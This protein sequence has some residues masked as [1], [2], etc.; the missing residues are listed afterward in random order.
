VA[1]ALLLALLPT[2]LP[3]LLRIQLAQAADAPASSPALGNAATATDG[4][5]NADLDAYKAQ[6]Q[7]IRALNDTGRVPLRSYPLS[8]AQCWLD[9][10]FHEYTQ[11][12]RSAFPQAAFDQSR[13]ITGWLAGGGKPG[14]VNDPSVTTPLVNSAAKVRDDLWGAVAALKT[15]PGFA[16]AAQ[17][18]ACAEVELVHAGNE[19]NQGGWRHAKPYVQ[20][21]EDNVAAAQ[22]AAAEC[23][24]PAEPPKPEPPKPLPLPPPCDCKPPAPIVL[25]ASAL[26][27]FDGRTMADLL[28]RGRIEIE[29]LARRLNEV[30][31]RID[32]IE[33]VGHTDRLGKDDYNRKLSADRAATVRAYLQQLGI[34]APMTVRGMGPSEPLKDV[35]CPG[36]DTAAVR[37]CLQPNRRVELNVRGQTR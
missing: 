16:C 12:D 20:I 23:P 22:R 33:V 10:S 4:R 27:K 26:F 35:D 1:A 7:A 36:P 3:P 25:S 21:A 2:L 32:G 9:V 24:P 13:V 5:V 17:L 6:Q 11:N 31:S 18:A 8:K 30:Y 29:I 34:T 37:A 28:P 19:M 15:G 14:D